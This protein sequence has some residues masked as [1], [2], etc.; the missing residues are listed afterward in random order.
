MNIQAKRI[1]YVRL[2]PTDI[3]P[4]SLTI[5]ASDLGW[6]PGVWPAHLEISDRYQVA[7]KLSRA[8]AIRNRE[9][10]VTGVWYIG[11]DSA[12]YPVQVS[13]FND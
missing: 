5:E 3:H 6:P 12:G 4:G 7:V 2:T 10:E 1:A 11:H 13:V 8:S 9:H